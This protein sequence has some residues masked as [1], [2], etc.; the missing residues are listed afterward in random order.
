[1]PLDFRDPAYLFDMVEV[2]KKVLGY[3]Q[4]KDYEDFL[5]DDLLQDAVERN[6]TILGEAARKLSEQFKRENP[7]IPWRRIIGLR[8]I[9]VH[10]YEDIDYEEIWE[11]ITIHLPILVPRLEAL[12]PPIPSDNDG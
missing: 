6:L 9:L 11:I 4:K 1:M 8:N 12:M 5:R 10:E 3:I 7:D 2:G